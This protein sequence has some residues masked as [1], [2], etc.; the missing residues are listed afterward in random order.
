MKRKA[1]NIT[2]TV[3]TL[4]NGTNKVVLSSM[5]EI[6]ITKLVPNPE[7]AVFR[8]EDELYTE[9]LEADIRARG[10]VVP[11]I[12]KRFESGRYRIIAGHRRVEIAQKIG[13]KTVPCQEV[14]SR[15]DEKAEREFVIKDNLLRRQLSNEDKVRLY[16]QLYGAP[17]VAKLFDP[18]SKQGRKVNGDDGLTIAQVAKDTGQSVKAVQKQVHRSKQKTRAEKKETLSPLNGSAKKKDSVRPFPENGDEL[19]LLLGKL[20]LRYN[21]ATNEVKKQIL[22]TVQNLL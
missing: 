5:R 18:E 16:E 2:S 11:I 6:E 15:L 8:R 20:E 3:G 13:L 10:I 22:E 21:N 1:I 7:N 19:K 4:S 12:I 14:T 17:A 9:K